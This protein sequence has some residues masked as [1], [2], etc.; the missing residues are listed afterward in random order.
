MQ[1]LYSSHSLVSASLG[2]LGGL[3]V[4]SSLSHGFELKLTCFY[5]V[6][7]VLS[8][9]LADVS[10][11]ERWLKGYMSSIKARMIHLLFTPVPR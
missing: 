10:A 7:Y 8:M 4:Q 5:L 2:G 11:D 1:S 3:I 6:A 9:Q